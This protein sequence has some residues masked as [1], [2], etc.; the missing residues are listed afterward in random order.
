MVK[1]LQITFI[2]VGILGVAVIVSGLIKMDKCHTLYENGVVTEK[3][4]R[5]IATLPSAQ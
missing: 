3:C 1:F 5:L 4:L 2:L